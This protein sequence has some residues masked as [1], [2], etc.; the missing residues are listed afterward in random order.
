MQAL[1]GSQLGD[2][3]SQLLRGE[4]TTT[5]RQA[6]QTYNHQAAITPLCASI[7]S[8][9]PINEG[10]TNTHAV[11]LAPVQATTSPGLLYAL[12]LDEH[13]Y[14][15]K[16]LADATS[17]ATPLTLPGNPQV[18]DIAA[19]ETRLVLLLNGGTGIGSQLGL[20]LPGQP[21][22]Q[23]T[24]A[25][26]PLPGDTPILVVAQGND[27]Y[28][29]LAPSTVAAFPAQTVQIV[30]FAVD[31]DNTFKPNP[32]TTQFQAPNQLISVA[33]FPNH[34]LFFLL[35]DGSVQSLQ[36]GGSGPSAALT[37]V[38][39]SAP[40][41]S[42]LVV[43]STDLS[44]T[45]VPTVPRAVA[46]ASSGPL[47]VPHAD[48]LSVGQ[49]GGRAHLYIGDPDQH[50]LLD[51]TSSSGGGV[52]GNSS[53]QGLQ[54]VAQYVSGTQLSQIKSIAVNSKEMKIYL[55]TQSTASPSSLLSISTT[56]QAQTPCA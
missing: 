46:S 11:R 52:V 54:L 43:S 39:V 10:S 7:A 37:P 17:L 25:I 29:I 24:I 23:T 8:V 3:A 45:P 13:L 4:L 49:P 14:Q 55:L 32:T 38:L 40:I 16:Q 1:E 28:V 44:Q 56:G 41:A 42:P 27:I 9:T 15:L 51:L 18:L 19:D 34:L 22:L 36:L 50:R 6:I 48:V 31:T 2:Q 12:G 47:V 20:L 21:Q 35:A 30:D 53:T 33:A 26:K 5:A